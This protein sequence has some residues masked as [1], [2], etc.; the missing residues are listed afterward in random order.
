MLRNNYRSC[1][2]IGHYHYWV[3]KPKKIR[4]RS[5]VSQKHV[6]AKKFNMVHQ[7]ISPHERVGSGDETMCILLLNSFFFFCHSL[8]FNGGLTSLL[9]FFLRV[10]SHRLHSAFV[11]ALGSTKYIR[12][13]GPATLSSPSS[14][15]KKRCPDIVV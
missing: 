1:N 15:T 10:S 13:K 6:L 2:L 12:Y 14:I 8:G 3:I 11:Y 4:L 9:F 7:T 5:P